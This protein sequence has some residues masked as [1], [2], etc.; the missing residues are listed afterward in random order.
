M[1]KIKT[2]QSILSIHIF[3]FICSI[4]ACS[5]AYIAFITHSSS[6]LLAF[7]FDLNW[8]ELFE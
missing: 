1:V 5:F 6:Y 3:K 7:R 8:I 4:V 2:F